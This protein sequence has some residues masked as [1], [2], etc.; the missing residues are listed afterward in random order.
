MSKGSLYPFRVRIKDPDLAQVLKM[1]SERRASS[2]K[3]P[4]TARKAGHKLKPIR[5]DIFIGHDNRYY[6]SF[7]SLPPEIDLE[8]LPKGKAYDFIFKNTF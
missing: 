7:I 6:R 1:V 3:K 2:I 5:K 8:C 4:G